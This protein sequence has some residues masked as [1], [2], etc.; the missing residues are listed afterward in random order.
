VPSSGAMGGMVSRGSSN[1]ASKSHRNGADEETWSL[2]NSEKTVASLA[3]LEALATVE[4][5]GVTSTEFSEKINNGCRLAYAS[6]LAVKSREEAR[7]LLAYI[8]TQALTTNPAKGIGGILFYDDETNAVVQVLE[9]PAKATRALYETISGDTRHTSVRKMWEIEID[10]RLYDGFG[11]KLGTDPSEVLSLKPTTDELLQLTYMSRLTASTREL[12]YKDIQDILRVAVFKN[13]SLHIGGALFLNP[14]TLHVLQVLE[15]PRAHVRPLYEKIA[16][17]ARHSACSV[18]SEVTVEARTY[19][20]WGMLQ[21]DLADWSALAGTEGWNVSKLP[22]RMR[23]FGR[24]NVDE[25]V[26]EESMHAVSK[27]AAVEG[28]PPSGVGATPLQTD[29]LKGHVQMG[30]N[31]PVVVTD[32]CAC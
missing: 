24:E 29:A 6:V 26:R 20:Q 19:D 18:V 1:K 7:A 15:G 10:S 28:S 17:D 32:A 13:P 5:K 23:R 31:G 8:F 12:A 4:A 16:T 11:M 30:P 27:P 22:R 9:G 14:R 2:A 3:R 21:G 25:S